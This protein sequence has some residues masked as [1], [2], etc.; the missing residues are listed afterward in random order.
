MKLEKYLNE[1]LTDINKSAVRKYLANAYKEL[2]YAKTAL[3][4]TEV[5]EKLKDE[6]NDMLEQLNQF[7]DRFKG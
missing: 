4:Q 1:V 5:G 6:L 2:N 7:K 3:K